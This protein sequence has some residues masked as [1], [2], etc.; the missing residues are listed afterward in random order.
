MIT[1]VG[2]S[3]QWVSVINGPTRNDRNPHV[4]VTRPLV[5]S[6]RSYYYN[7]CNRQV[8]LRIWLWLDVFLFPLEGTWTNTFD[9][10]FETPEVSLLT[11]LVSIFWEGDTELERTLFSFAKY[12]LPPLVRF[13]SVVEDFAS[14]RCSRRSLPFE[15]VLSSFL[16]FVYIVRLRCRSCKQIH[17]ICHFRCWECPLEFSTYTTI[18]ECSLEFSSSS[19]RPRRSIQN[20]KSWIWPGVSMCVF[21]CVF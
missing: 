15:S 3:I 9:V 17:F 10:T 13:V 14:S 8:R 11:T 1:K 16:S 18:W 21:V 7:P 2:H 12:V 19:I 5:S 20:W 6:R 4:R